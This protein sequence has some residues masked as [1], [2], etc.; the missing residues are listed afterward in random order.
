MLFLLQHRPLHPAGTGRAVRPCIAPIKTV[1]ILALG[2]IAGWFRGI[3][4]IHQIAASG[5][6]G[7]SGADLVRFGIIHNLSLFL[8]KY[9][10]DQSACI[11]KIP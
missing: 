1:W 5:P 9:S 11:D 6:I 2:A 4:G 7:T 10:T 3:S 8:I